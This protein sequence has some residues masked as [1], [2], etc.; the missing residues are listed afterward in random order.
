M[1]KKWIFAGII[2]VGIYALFSGE[3][4]IHKKGL[5]LASVSGS[6]S[7][8]EENEVAYFKGEKERLEIELLNARCGNDELSK[9]EEGI[10]GKVYSSYPFSDKS[11]ILI[12]VGSN[13]GVEVGSAVVSNNFL[14]GKIKEVYKSTSVVSTVMDPGMKIPARIGEKEIDALYAGG[15]H[16]QL[17]LIDSKEAIKAGEIIISADPNLPY[18]L[19]L[20]KT[21]S[22]KE[23]LIKEAAIDPAIEIKSLRDVSVIKSVSR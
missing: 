3:S 17:D 6:F 19:G 4:F 13:D 22:V 14:V 16:P 8:N 5:I 9:K 7:S 1:A 15:L 20:G 10:K 23:G 21:M 11:E 18:G 2:G 12:S